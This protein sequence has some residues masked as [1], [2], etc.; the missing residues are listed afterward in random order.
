[1]GLVGGPPNSLEPSGHTHVPASS[2]WPLG[3]SL[4]TAPPTPTAPHLPAPHLPAL[5]PGL[6]VQRTQ[7]CGSAVGLAPGRVQTGVR[8][9][10]WRGAHTRQAGAL[11]VLGSVSGPA[12]PGQRWGRG[13]SGCSGRGSLGAAAGLRGVVRGRGCPEGRGPAGP[14]A[15]GLEGVGVR[16]PGDRG[17]SGCGGSGRV[18]FVGDQVSGSCRGWLQA[19]VCGAGQELGRQGHVCPLV[20]LRPVWA[21]LVL[22]GGSVGTRRGGPGHSGFHSNGREEPGN[23]SSGRKPAAAW[24]EPRASLAEQ[25]PDTLSV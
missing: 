21:R 18:T 17:Q 11:R 12:R 19:R 8:A 20:L 5:S 15:R 16:R 13:V 24:R 23:T 6:G 3:S 25:A 4:G 22:S 7:G 1:M 9:S 2:R 14:R 10:C